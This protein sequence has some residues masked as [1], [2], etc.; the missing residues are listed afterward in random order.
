MNPK[1]TLLMT[2]L[3]HFF[4]QEN[5]YQQLL[6]VLYGKSV[7]SLRIIDW[8]VTNYAKD[9]T[10]TNP[11]NDQPFLVYDNYKSQLRAYSKRQF[12]PFCRRTR[13]TFYYTPHDKIIT[14]VGQLNF[15]RW[16][17]ANGVIQYIEENIQH[18]DM[19]MKLYTKEYKTRKKKDINNDDITASSSS[20]S[21]SAKRN[22]IKYDFNVILNF[23]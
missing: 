22:I 16:A 23:E 17:I 6:P 11:A 20:S 5:H 7:A 21:S 3:D 9:L 10:Y 14:T 4:T 8:F 19:A 1:Q 13:I 2:S 15:F 18:I 12:D